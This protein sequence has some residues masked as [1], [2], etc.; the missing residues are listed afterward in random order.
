MT[1]EFVPLLKDSPG[2]GSRP[3]AAVAAFSPLVQT[4]KPSPAQEPAGPSN[5]P[6]GPTL[7]VQRHGERVTQIQIRCT[8]GQV[9]ELDCDY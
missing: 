4:P 9:I 2:G 5:A 6:P 1:T 8:C 3:E 7:S